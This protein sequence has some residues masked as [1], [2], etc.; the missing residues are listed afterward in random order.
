[1]HLTLRFR[2]PDGTA[3]QELLVYLYHTDATGRYR[4]APSA[5][6]CARF[7]GVLR[8]WAHPDANGAVHVRSIRPGAYPA[9]AEPAHVHVIVQFPNRRGYYVNDVLF[10]DDARVTSSVRN[11]QR[12]LGGP[13]VVHAVRDSSGVWRATREIVLQRPTR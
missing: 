9:S 5:T 2:T 10:D 13:G 4:P 3:L 1:M 7:H 8:G 6:G 12:A 11:N